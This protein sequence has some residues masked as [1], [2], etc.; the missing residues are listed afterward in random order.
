MIQA[1]DRIK[2]KLFKA[3]SKIQQADGA[4]YEKYICIWT[5]KWN[6]SGFGCVAV[7]KRV[8]GGRLLERHGC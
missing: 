4:L 2:K 5:K 1:P 8:L 6:A 7:S 3:W